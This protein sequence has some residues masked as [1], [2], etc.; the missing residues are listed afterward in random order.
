MEFQHE[1]VIPDEGLP[2]KFFLFEGK[3]CIR[4][5]ADGVIV[6]SA[7]V[8]LCETHGADCVPY[9]KEYVKSMKDAIR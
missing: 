4:D 7:I 2:F 3:M 5:R 8:K 6:G 9:I 1:L